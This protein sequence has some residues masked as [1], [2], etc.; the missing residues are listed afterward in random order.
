MFNLSK[1]NNDNVTPYFQEAA[2]AEGDSHPHEPFR[3]DDPS[4]P[5]ATRHLHRPA[6][7]QGGRVHGRR[8]GRRRGRHKGHRQHGGWV[9]FG[10]HR[11]RPWKERSFLTKLASA[12]HWQEL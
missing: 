10:W 8:G 6:G 9:Y 7:G 1:N 5:G 11:G 12:L 3:L 4:V 2:Q